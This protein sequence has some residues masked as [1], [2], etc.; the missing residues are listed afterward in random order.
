M[1]IDRFHVE[2][3]R[4]IGRAEL[5]L[6]G[7]PAWLTGPNGAGK[8]SLLEALCLLGYGRSFRGRP[9]QGLIRRGESALEVVAHWRDGT[10][11]GHVS[12]LRHGGELW[13]ARRDG[14]ALS[15]LGGLAESFP[16]LCFHPASSTL[17]Q[18]PAEERRRA[19]D[20]LVFH[21]E[22]GF[23]S[24]A[25]RYAR[26]L[27][28]RNALL[29]AAAPD[30]EFEPWEQE[31]GRCAQAMTRQRVAAAG[32]LEQALASVWLRLREDSPPPLGLRPGW[33]AEDSALEDLLLLNRSRDREL[34][35]TTIGPHRADLQFGEAFGVPPEHWSRGQAKLVAL[36]L[37]LAQAEALREACGLT[38]LLLFDDLGAELDAGHLGRLLYWLAQAPYQCLV[39]GTGLPAACPVEVT[40]W[41]VFHVEQGGV[42]PLSPRLTGLAA[43]PDAAPPPGGQGV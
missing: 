18:G 28:Q 24:L 17:A 42:R 23:S 21:L 30:A 43:A 1:R 41:P 13:T 9:G 15:T 7:N 12:G 39:T 33:R 34:G 25:R 16:V 10:G 2:H 36:A 26:A 37:C 29:R 19:L 20:W 32:R 14:E 38:S 11:Q 35:Y 3:L 5:E 4:C 8:T 31:L 22:P 27:R 6:A 40:R